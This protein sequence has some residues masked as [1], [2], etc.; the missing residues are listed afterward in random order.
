MG[1]E[2]KMREGCSVGKSLEA[3]FIYTQKYYGFSGHTDHESKAIVSWQ[4]YRLS[5][6]D[7]LRLLERKTTLS[8]IVNF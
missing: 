2:N 6:F 5:D 1:D 8:P 3:F 7:L 4:C